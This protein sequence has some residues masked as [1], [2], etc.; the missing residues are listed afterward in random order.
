VAL[1]QK[2]ADAPYSVVL[3]CLEVIKHGL[4]IYGLDD[5][6]LPCGSGNPALRPALLAPQK[7]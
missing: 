1:L 2:D 3:R 5:F 7:G 4:L 6:P